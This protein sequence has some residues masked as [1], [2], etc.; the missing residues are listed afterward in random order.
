LSETKHTMIVAT[1][2]S[3]LINLCHVERLYILSK[4]PGLKFTITEYVKTEIT[5][6]D[7]LKQV[8]EA[9]KDGCISVEVITDIEEIHEYAE[10]NK[11]LGKGEAACLAMAEHRNWLVACDEK[12]RVFI[13]EAASR[14]GRDRII[15][16][17]DLVVRAIK[18]SVISVDEADRWISVWAR[19]RFV[20]KI[21]SFREL[22]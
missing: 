10:L 6:D 3:I 8:E 7:Q 16:T 14:L 18:A 11:V 12:N 22:L 15:T 17:S 1:D 20:V 19:N 21:N 4:L 9:I 13:R 2:T 5:K